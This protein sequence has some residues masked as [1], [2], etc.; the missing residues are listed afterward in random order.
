MSPESAG[1]FVTESFTFDGGTWAI[2]W[3]V[4][5][6][7]LRVAIN[8]YDG[9][10]SSQL[11]EGVNAAPDGQGIVYVNRKGPFYLTIEATAKWVVKV[12]AVDELGDFS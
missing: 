1:S 5:G 2:V 8:T 6:G 7:D 10:A 9:S 11:Q 3:S 4:G 12:V